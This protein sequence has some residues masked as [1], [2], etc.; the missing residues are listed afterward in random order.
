LQFAFGIFLISFSFQVNIMETL[1]HVD[2]NDR[3]IGKVDRKTAH[4]KGILH[5]SGIV[6]L[7]NSEGKV[8]ITHRSPNKETFPDRYD[9]SAAFHVRYGESYM[10]AAKRELKEETGISARV[11]YVGKFVHHDE[12]EHEFV[13]VFTAHTDKRIKLDASESTS[14]RFYDMQQV[15]A[16]VA[17]SKV[18][19]W[20]KLGWK[21]L[22]E[23]EGKQ[24]G[25]KEV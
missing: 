15:N 1:Y 14:G 12:P 5:R 21:L 10:Q 18:T 19:P 17:N 25:S 11:H 24:S 7:F 9:A 8:L 4:E 20:F 16:I 2:K 13:A 6:F 3:I 22:I 23:K